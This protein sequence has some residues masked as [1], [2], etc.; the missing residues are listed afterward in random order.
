MLPE[1]IECCKKCLVLYNGHMV[2]I[3][4]KLWQKL[5][6]AKFLHMHF[7]IIGAKLIVFA[8][9][10]MGLALIKVSG[11]FS[12]TFGLFGPLTWSLY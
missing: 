9:S 11:F 1:L 8:V 5:L 12:P 7:K 3:L 4:P 6:L 2:K 10:D